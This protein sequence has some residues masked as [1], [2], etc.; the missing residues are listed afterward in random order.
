MKRRYELPL[1]VVAY[2]CAAT[3]G[4]WPMLGP[5]LTATLWVPSGLMLGILVTSERSEWLRYAAIAFVVDALIEYVIYDFSAVA[6]CVVAFANVSEALFGA[7]LVRWWCGYP[8]RFDSVRDILALPLL[9]AIPATTIS[10][11]LGASTL[12]LSGIQEFKPAWLLWWLG[13]A[14]GVL[15]VAPL[16]ITLRSPEY[17]SLMR[18]P[19]HRVVLEAAA[20]GIGLVVACH[21]FYTGAVPFSF[22]ILPFLV[23]AAVRFGMRGTAIAMATVA[24]MTFSYVTNGFEPFA[25]RSIDP[26]SRTVA[27]QAYLAVVAVSAMLLAAISEQHQR[28]L[29]D[30]KAAQVALR[31]LVHDRTQ[32]LRVS[33][34]L[35]ELA[36]ESAQAAEWG[37]N[38]EADTLAWSSRYRALYGFDDEEQGSFDTWLSRV[39][40][41]D[42]DRV[43]RRL[44]RM[45]CTPGEDIWSEEFRILHPNKGL[46]WL[47]G[48]AL[49]KRD[50]DG[51]PLSMTGINID[52]T[53]RRRVEYQLGLQQTAHAKLARLGAL[54][55]VS[56]GIAHEITQP[57]MAA[58]TYTRLIQSTL[59]H[60]DADIV[61]AKQAA[62]K[63]E[64]QIERASEV[65]R[66]LRNLIK[67]G[68][69][70]AA[71]TDLSVLVSQ[72]IELMRHELERHEIAVHDRLPPDLELVIVDPLQM[73][74]V[75]INLLRNASD[76]I[77]E[78]G[79]KSGNIW[80]ELGTTRDNF[81]EFRVRDS[82]PGFPPDRL[83]QP[84]QH[85]MTT[86][87]DGL[88]IGLSL[89]ASIVTAHGGTLWIG[90][91][92][93]GGA[94]YFTLKFSSGAMQCG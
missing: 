12:A 64:Q 79:Q 11:T 39:H 31:G 56:A 82:G 18:W 71:P 89:S 15:I 21:L 7:T 36:L 62:S 83:R 34:E 4:Q 23:W 90:P 43:K 87:A 65:V 69:I 57:L 24:A 25:L 91:N 58:G 30:L 77:A 59:S 46:V 16:F 68:R 27:I 22:I 54:G 93:P 41:D 60:E 44:D 17:T 29:N 61:L 73:V 84:P 32:A 14:I 92:N 13:D 75:I 33:E 85:F 37:W 50:A 48:T 28:A 2:A 74:Q 19:G 49:L 10:A 35:K 45:L 88:G 8:F 66:R 42:R 72:A 26:Y 9:S 3:V 47:G 81:G 76:A 53:Q 94:V 63:A 5:G 80:I 20:L 86:K 51:R 78:A 70:E 52:V 6:S 38:V 40:P 1:F 67:L 55:E